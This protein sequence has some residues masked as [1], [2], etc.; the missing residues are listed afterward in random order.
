MRV[1]AIFLIGAVVGGVGA[2]FAGPHV[3]HWYAQ[4]PFAMGCDC[5]PAMN[6]AMGKLVIVELV[7][8][9]LGAIALGAF[10]FIGFGNRGGKKV[11]T[12]TTT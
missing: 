1:F 9:M 5:G 3:I 11:V 2:A 6:W 4:P 8:A 12:T 10:A 7:G